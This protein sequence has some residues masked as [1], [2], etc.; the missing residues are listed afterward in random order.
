MKV[1]LSYVKCLDCGTEELTTRLRKGVRV[2]CNH[3]GP[4]GIRCVGSRGTK[5]KLMPAQTDSKV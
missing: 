3:D 4:G 5:W 2:V 1:M